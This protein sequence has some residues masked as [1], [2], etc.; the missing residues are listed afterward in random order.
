MEKHCNAFISL[1]FAI[2]SIRF[3]YY[4]YRV[5]SANPFY[6]WFGSGSD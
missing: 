3:L 1:T 5:L 6:K 2:V 4:V